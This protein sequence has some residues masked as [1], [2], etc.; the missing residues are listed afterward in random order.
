[1]VTHL[2]S[3][4]GGN[5]RERVGGKSCANKMSATAWPDLSKTSGFVL[6]GVRGSTDP[7][8]RVFGGT[9]LER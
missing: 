5:G 2:G 8:Y 9:S 4:S 7:I 1:M 6:S 3:D